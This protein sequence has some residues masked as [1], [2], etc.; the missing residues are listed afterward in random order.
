MGSRTERC[1]YSR[2]ALTWKR[3]PSPPSTTSRVRGSGRNRPN[4][5]GPVL[6]A[7]LF[8]STRWQASQPSCMN[9][10]LPSATRSLRSFSL[11]SP[12]EAWG[13]FNCSKSAGSTRAL[14]SANGPA[15]RTK[16]NDGP[17][18]SS[19]VQNAPSLAPSRRTLRRK[20]VPL[21]TSRTKAG[22][23]LLKPSV[24]AGGAEPQRE[25]LPVAVADELERVSPL[26]V[27]HGAR[28]GRRAEIEAGDAVGESGPRDEGS[29]ACF[30]LRGQRAVGDGPRR[31]VPKCVPGYGVLGVCD[32]ETCERG[33]GQYRY[34]V[35]AQ[36]LRHETPFVCGYTNA[37]PKN[38]KRP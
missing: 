25:G 5:F 17:R 1:R 26:H 33:D 31:I 38:E 36:E 11:V 4:R 22:W 28:A 21:R 30:G 3:C 13:T 7:A 8:F 16:M 10:S 20:S 18:R 14:R 32:M 19:L 9:D 34:W 15:W 37:I 2:L 35:A 23:V 27:Q 24:E 12:P 6:T 29:L